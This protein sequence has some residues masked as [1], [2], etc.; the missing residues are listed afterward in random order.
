MNISRR[1]TAF[2]A[3][4]ALVKV[5]CPRISFVEKCERKYEKEE[6]NKKIKR[7][8]EVLVCSADTKTSVQRQLL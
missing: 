8:I 2:I 1:N 3:Y 4:G 7:S 5:Q 6:K